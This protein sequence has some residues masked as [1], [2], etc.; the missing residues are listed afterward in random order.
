M[1]AA[2]QANS[3]HPDMPMGMAGI[4]EALWHRHIRRY[5]VIRRRPNHDRFAR[6]SSHNSLRIDTP[7]RLI[8]DD[9][10]NAHRTGVRPFHT[11]N[12]RPPEVIRTRWVKRTT[13]PPRR[14]VADCCSRE[15]ESQQVCS[16]A[17][18][19][20]WAVASPPCWP[21]AQSRGRSSALP[22]RTRS[23]SSQPTR[24]LPRAMS[25]GP[26]SRRPAARFSTAGTPD[27]KA[28][29]HVIR[30]LASEVGIRGCW[31]KNVGLDGTIIGIDRFAEPAT[32]GQ[33][34]AFFGFTVT[35]MDKTAK[36]L[37]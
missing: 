15:G 35:H 3:S 36:S 6:A 14:C 33:L 31:R 21:S 37:L 20:D 24:H 18:A 1:D 25:R 5:R 17:T 12:P 7:L 10:S 29:C 9:F 16:L 22:D 32:A 2:Q 34:F 28:S 11:K 13:C 23:A 4:A 26:S 8:P 19:Q 30:F 27:R